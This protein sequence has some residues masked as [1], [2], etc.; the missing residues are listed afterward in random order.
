MLIA[1]LSLAAF[2]FLSGF[3]SKD[4]ILESAF[5]QFTFSGIAVYI[6]ATIGAIFTTLYSVKVLY[7]TF[8]TTPN[9]SRRYFGYFFKKKRKILTMDEA[10]KFD[11][12][13][14]MRNERESLYHYLT[15]KY[16]NMVEYTW[17]D[18]VYYEALT[19]VPKNKIEVWVKDY[20]SFRNIKS[21][22]YLYTRSIKL[23][24]LPSEGNIYMTLPLVILAVFSIFF[25]FFT[26]EIF[27]GL[28]SNFLTGDNSIFIHPNHEIVIDTEF[29]VPTIFKLLPFFCT[30]IFSIL[31][32]IVSEFRPESL[33]NFKFS[34][35][36]YNIFGLFNQ[37]FLIEM[38]YN[39]YITNLVLNLGG[40]TTK[41][42]DKGSIEFLGPFGLEKGFIRLS[43]NINTLNT[44]IVTSYAL[45]LLLGFILFLTL[46]LEQLTGNITLLILIFFFSLLSFQDYGLDINWEDKRESDKRNKSISRNFTV[47]HASV[48]NLNKSLRDWKF[49]ITQ[50]HS[51]R[52][53]S[54]T[55]YLSYPDNNSEDSKSKEITDLT[56]KK[57]SL[58]EVIKE[59]NQI[60]KI[61]SDG[62]KLDN[63]LPEEV[64]S[65]NSYIKEIEK[66][67]PEIKEAYFLNS[68][69][70]TVNWLDL[71]Q[72][73]ES[74]Q[75]MYSYEITDLNLQ[76]QKLSLKSS[77]EE[78]NKTLKR[79]SDLDIDSQSP[80]K[81]PYHKD[82]G[83]NGSN[84]KFSGDSCGPS[85]EGNREEE[86]SK[87]K[88]SEDKSSEDKKS[89]HNDN[90]GKPSGTGGNNS[91]G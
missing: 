22:S 14:E 89:D 85:Q 15:G 25:G 39:K 12:I 6:I 78:S 57:T 1:S 53:F 19:S 8:L 17:R 73:I 26:K 40:Q 58:S 24:A 3:Y 68:K 77:K 34:R 50:I 4:F 70:P 55:N 69:S 31:A 16:M 38:F 59:N 41:V 9:G 43:K 11:K 87:N 60:L 27:I 36:G 75:I 74:E 52:M 56:D 2:P 64:K 86:S 76:L 42:L 5:G 83:G 44:S 33:I 48:F 67:D 90:S 88:S 29:A 82:N 65:K 49:I 28:G 80:F 79:E 71:K 51:K 47:K 45:F 10:V 54:S 62:I 30:I 63:K 13:L 32:I 66:I 91:G 72:D 23:P 84:S 18:S 7:L 21:P 37:R 61:V 46:Y 20:L 81:K 35:L